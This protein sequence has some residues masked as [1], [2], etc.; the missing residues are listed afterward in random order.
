MDFRKARVAILTE[1]GDEA[2]IVEGKENRRTANRNNL[3]ESSEI[4]IARGSTGQ[5]LIARRLVP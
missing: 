4:N 2:K 5:S 3:V 1:T